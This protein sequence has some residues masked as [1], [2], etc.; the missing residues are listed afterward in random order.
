M[1]LE[2]P[3]V[4][5]RGTTN[6]LSSGES[7]LLQAL[8][9]YIRRI[10]RKAEIAERFDGGVSRVS[11]T[12]IELC[13][14]RMGRRLDALALNIRTHAARIGRSPQAQRS[15]NRSTAVMRNYWIRGNGGAT[16]GDGD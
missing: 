13:I 8:I 6:E 5:A 3:V 2:D 12:T 15:T 16:I 9:T 7:A 4:C 11:D 10:V 14:Q 1:A